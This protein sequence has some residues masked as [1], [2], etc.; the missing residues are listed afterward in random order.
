MVLVTAFCT[1]LQ[2]S[3]LRSSHM[4]YIFQISHFLK[5]RTL[6]YLSTVYII[7]SQ[8]KFRDLL[9]MNILLSSKQNIEEQG[10]FKA[11]TDMKLRGMSLQDGL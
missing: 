4:V 1:E 10:P 3:V 9:V 7:I 5:K 8:R 11:K 2:T 6:G